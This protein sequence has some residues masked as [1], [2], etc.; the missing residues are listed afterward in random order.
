[1]PSILY[2]YDLEGR[3]NAWSNA[4]IIEVLGRTPEQVLALGPDLLA[5]LVHPDDL[6]RVEA[7]FRSIAGAA[8]GEVREAEYRM[9]HAD[10]SWR[11]LRCREL[12]FRRGEDGRVV[13]VLGS[14]DDVTDRRR[15]QAEL[16]RA[17]T[18][19]ADAVE[20]LDAGLV[21]FDADERLVICNRRFRAM[22][23]ALADLM[24]PGATYESIVRAA[25]RVYPA[26]DEFGMD[27]EGRVARRLD[28]FRHQKGTSYEVGVGGRWSRVGEFA[29]SECGT[30]C[31]LTDI[32]DL[33][34]H[35]EEL[36]HARD[37]AQAAARAKAEFLANMSH[38]IRT[39]M[40]GVL[41][42][43]ELALGT[44]LT[45]RQREYLA[46]IKSS[47]ESLLTVIDDILD[48]SKI[49]A[50]RLELDPAPFGLRALLDDTLRAFAP[51]AHERGLEL[52]C[53][54]APGA[55]RPA[56]RPAPAP[57][58][59]RQPRRQRDQVHRA[60]RG[61]RARSTPKPGPQTAASPWPSPSATP[62]SASPPT[63]ARPSS[64]P[65]SRPTAR[66]RV[67]TAGRAWA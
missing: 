1:M 17:R 39:P 8:D 37:E 36:R 40:N 26:E 64:A 42:M 5:A 41:G 18:Q 10:G 48:F 31:L 46:A 22:Y 13:Q 38:E 66:R 47:A 58:G 4:R 30:V 28:H 45:P 49:E 54:I 3:R 19:L 33:K 35:E 62:A 67:V 2:V 53:R 43:A 21:M 34:R 29:T 6:P 20:S 55:R 32:T 16:A 12:A 44:P 15:E 11:W 7:H 51:R 9:R 56:R 57:P 52:A 61:R 65:S 59:A 14:A 50:G 27:E 63:A 23:P 60:G 24:T 25:A